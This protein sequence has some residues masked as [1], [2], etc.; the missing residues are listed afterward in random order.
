MF[1]IFLLIPLQAILV[2]KTPVESASSRNLYNLPLD[3]L[4]IVIIRRVTPRRQSRRL[5]L[6]HFF[7]LLLQLAIARFKLH[8]PLGGVVQGLDHRLHLELLLLPWSLQKM[9]RNLFLQLLIWLNPLSMTILIKKTLP[10]RELD[11]LPML[12]MGSKKQTRLCLSPRFPSQCG[13]PE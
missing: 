6:Q 12:W 2:L 9:S 8:F 10:Q 4:V 13:S 11:N 7:R 1:P 3:N 5:P